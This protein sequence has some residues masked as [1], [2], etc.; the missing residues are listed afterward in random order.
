[1]RWSCD[2]AVPRPEGVPVEA[3]LH[4]PGGLGDFLS[5]SLEGR[6]VLTEHPFVGRVDFPEGGGVEWAI[7]WPEDE[8]DGFSH[9]YCNTIPTAEGG[10]HEA[11]LRNA[12]VRGVKGYAELVGN[13]RIAQATGEDVASGAAAL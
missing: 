2:P 10:T 5:A 3:R 12:L 8:E 7:A 13:R 11:G 1:I 4:F 9:S 6:A